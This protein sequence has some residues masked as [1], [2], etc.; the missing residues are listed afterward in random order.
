MIQMFECFPEFEYIIV[1]YIQRIRG[2]GTEYEVITNAARELQTY[3]R[4]TGK[5]FI[6]C[7][8]ASRQS[9]D[10]TKYDSNNKKIVLMVAKLE[11]KVQALSK[12]MPM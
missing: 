4:R 5:K 2:I 9:N 12:K 7:S 3:A 8:Q 11:E 6:I 10:S 1:D